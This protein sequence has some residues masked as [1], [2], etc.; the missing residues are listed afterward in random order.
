MTHDVRPPHAGPGWAE[1]AALD[2]YAAVLDPADRVGDKN[3]LIDQVHKQALARVMPARDGVRVVDFGCGTGR[4]AEW[5]VARG[6]TVSG[7]DAT[8][9]MVQRAR[10]AV[11]QASFFEIDGF[12][13][14]FEAGSQDVVLSVYVLQ[15]YVADRDATAALLAEFRRVLAPGGQ[16]IAI[17]QA[18]DG[19][20]GR[21]ATAGRYR[22]SLAAAGYQEVSSTPVRLGHSR[23]MRLSERWPRLGRG[24][25]VPS[26]VTTEA[27]CMRSRLV[28]ERYADTL[29]RARA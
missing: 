6:A 8:P 15:Y 29:F 12:A 25:I 26:L 13:L 23:V 19:D 27:R 7:V 14:P 22:D 20:I 5:L 16:V 3:A 9:E 18:T 24:A 2:R 4:L 21:G 17:E 1:L 10:A 11:P 28:G